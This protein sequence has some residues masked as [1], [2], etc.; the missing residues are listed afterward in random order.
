MNLDIFSVNYDRFLI[1][2]SLEMAKSWKFNR[3][4]IGEAPLQWTE[5]TNQNHH[6]FSW[7]GDIRCVDDFVLAFTIKSRSFLHRICSHLWLC[8][9]VFLSVLC[10]HSTIVLNLAVLFFLNFHFW[11]FFI[12]SSFICEQFFIIFGFMFI[13]SIIN[14]RYIQSIRNSKPQHEKERFFRFKKLTVL[15][16]QQ[17]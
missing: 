13:L 16:Q 8:S 2:F 15:P 9:T 1:W 7:F 11:L 12:L 4:F 17:A 14:L 10:A 5:Q 3:I 6:R